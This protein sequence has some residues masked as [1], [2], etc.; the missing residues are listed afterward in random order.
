MILRSESWSTSANMR[1]RKAL[2]ESWRPN[3][4]NVHLAVQIHAS[5]GQSLL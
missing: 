2:V 3:F 1:S 4:M 5:I